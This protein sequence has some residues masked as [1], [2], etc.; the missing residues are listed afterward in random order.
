MLTYPENF[1]TD[2]QTNKQTNPG[3]NMTSP[4]LRLAEVI[5]TI[6]NKKV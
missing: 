5:I 4:K 1:I 3:E 6:I 2:R